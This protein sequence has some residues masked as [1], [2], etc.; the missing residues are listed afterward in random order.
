MSLTENLVSLFRIDAQVR[1]LRRRLES[2]ERYLA[3]QNRRV[4]DLAAQRQEL[5]ARHRQIQAKIANLESETAALDER[6]EK[7]RNEL[8]AATTNKQY[9]AVLHELNTAKDARSEIEDVV[10]QEL[11]RIDENKLLRDALEQDSAEREKVRAVAE[12]QLR[13]RHEEV[14]QRLAELEADR[15]VAA[16]AIPGRELRIFNEL[17]DA[18]DGEPMASIEEIDRRRREYACGACNMHIPFQAVSAL[19]SSSDT[20]VQCT[21]CGRIMYLQDETRGALTKR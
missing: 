17:A 8:N 7:L 3:A 5:D 11:E 19:L 4:D 15:G 10:L 20:L 13:Q 16:A 2:A 18:Y 12:E 9:T 1:G 21:A 14:G 6:L